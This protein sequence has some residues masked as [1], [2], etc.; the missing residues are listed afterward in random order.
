MLRSVGGTLSMRHHVRHLY[1]VV[2]S[3]FGL[4]SIGSL[5]ADSQTVLVEQVGTYR[6][7]T[8]VEVKDRLWWEYI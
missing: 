2:V 8:L 3:S 6:L 4:L 1:V 7:Y 5:F